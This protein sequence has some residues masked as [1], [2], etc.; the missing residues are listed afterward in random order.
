ME[1]NMRKRAV[2][3]ITMDDETFNMLK[4][5]RAKTK[6]PMAALIREAIERFLANQENYGYGISKDRED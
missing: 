5:L 4:E 2:T 3:T 6:V 1:D